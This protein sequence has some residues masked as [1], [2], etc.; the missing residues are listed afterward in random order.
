MVNISINK[1]KLIIVTLLLL[2]LLLR[3]IITTYTYNFKYKSVNGYLKYT[4]MVIDK[5]SQNEE[6]ITY[7]VAMQDLNS[8]KF[9]DRFLLKLKDVINVY[10][11]GD[12]LEVYGYISIPK[13]LG[14][15]GEFNYKNY[16]NSKKIVGNMYTKSCEQVYSVTGN[17]FLR[18]IKKYKGYVS[19]KLLEYLDENNAG[20]IMG[21]VYGDTEHISIETKEN[22]EKIGI[23]HLTAVSGS[24]VATV[25]M[26]ITYALDKFKINKYVKFLIQIIFILAFLILCNSELSIMRAC[27]MAICSIIFKLLGKKYSVF[28]SMAISL[29]IILLINPYSILNVGMQLS[30]VASLSLILF[31]KLVENGVKKICKISSFEE[32]VQSIKRIPKFFKFIFKVPIAILEFL[33]LTISAQILILP[34]Q[35][36]YFKEYPLSNFI[37]NIVASFLDTP[38]CIIGVVS[39]LFIWIP[40][41]S[42][43]LVYVTSIFTKLLI[44]S[45]QIISNFAYNVTFKEQS[46]VVYVVYYTLI[47]FMWLRSSSLFTKTIK[48][49]SKLKY[50]CSLAII[51]LILIL[52]TVFTNFFPKEFVYFFNVGQ[53]SMNLVMSSN[54]CVLIDAGST[55]V[56]TAYN[57]LEA[58]FKNLNR[59]KIDIIVVTHFDA[60]HVNAIPEILNNFTV[61]KLL[62][63]NVPMTSEYSTQILELAKS[64]NVP[65]EAVNF[66]YIANIGNIQLEIFSPTSKYI[67]YGESFSNDNSLVCSVSLN[68]TNILFMGDATKYTEKMLL[69]DESKLKRKWDILVVGHH[70]S[71]TSTTEEFVQKIMPEVAVISAKKSVYGH[72]SQTVLEILRKYNIR[73]YITENLGGIKYKL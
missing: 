56:N 8:Q 23:S 69:Y 12:V 7:L 57:V 65:Y 28:Y 67:T 49:I 54:A 19:T 38:I 50:R 1:S 53:G 24:N 64:N 2:T 30:F 11:Y 44:V 31:S 48:R 41:A 52:V 3:C 26:V 10:K 70:G 72:P 40:Y 35:I 66:G 22:F 43:F 9:K 71:S 59:V 27:I 32:K 45:S 20:V 13:I 34:L 55:N 42:N 5:Y 36:E 18:Y 62:I 29:Y 68:E 16:L 58:F 39:V 6:S 17:V 61:G 33:S 51:F 73:I 15:E 4:V 47:L 14:N 37:A 25:I 60:D 63:P 46:I 21:M